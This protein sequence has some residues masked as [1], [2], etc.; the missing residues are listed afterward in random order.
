MKV[1]VCVLGG[2]EGQTS[3][4]CVLSILMP[5]P[6]PRGEEKGSGY[7]TTSRPTLEGRNQHIIVSAYIC[8][9]WYIFNATWTALWSLLL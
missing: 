4:S 9:I 8:H 1:S 2:R 5:R 6:H 7:D 3:I